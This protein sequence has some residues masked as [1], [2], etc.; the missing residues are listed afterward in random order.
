FGFGASAHLAIQVALDWKCDVYAFTREEHRRQLAHEMGA[1]WAGRTDESP[2]VALDAAV[3][4]APAGEIVVAALACLAPGAVVAVNAI[5]MSPIPSFDY[6]TLYGE[7]AVRSVM[8]FT[9]RDAEEFLALAARIPIRARTEIF[10]L[11][12]AN[13]ALASVKDGAVDGAA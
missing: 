11:E 5:H 6:E 4:F 8:N 7:R 12:D 3:T 1:V 9:R 13:R 10:P 2:G